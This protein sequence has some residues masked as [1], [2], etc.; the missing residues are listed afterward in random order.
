M[1]LRSRVRRLTLSVLMKGKP[2]SIS[3]ISNETGLSAT[4]VIGALRGVKGQYDPRLSLE[5][6]QLA[7]EDIYHINKKKHQRLYSL[8]RSSPLVLE[9]IEQVMS[10]YHKA[11]EV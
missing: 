3:E 7:R 9:E 8:M 5:R 6:L 1:A 10:R 2:C 4:Q 11:G